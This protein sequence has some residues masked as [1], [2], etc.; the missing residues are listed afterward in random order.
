MRVATL[1]PS[2]HRTVMVASPICPGAGVIVTV[3]F[4]PL[5][6]HTLGGATALSTLWLHHLV[7][8]ICREWGAQ[9]LL[10]G[11]LLEAGILTD[12][13]FPGMPADVEGRFFW[14][15]DRIVRGSV[16]DFADFYVGAYHWPAFNVAD[17]AICAGVALIFLL[18]WRNERDSKPAES[19]PATR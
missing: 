10:F 1:V 18:T 17:S 2:L 14:L 8:F 5:P 12:A 6:P 13:D 11:S 9:R 3:R 4:D 7:E 19:A 16:V 15:L